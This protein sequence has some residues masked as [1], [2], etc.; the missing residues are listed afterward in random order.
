MLCR[1]VDRYLCCGSICCFHLQ[2]RG[3]FGPADFGNRLAM[4]QTASRLPLT[5]EVQVRFHAGWRWDFNKECGT[6]T[7]F[8]F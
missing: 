6:A 8:F 3:A 5:S 4:A 7:G 2:N 1:F